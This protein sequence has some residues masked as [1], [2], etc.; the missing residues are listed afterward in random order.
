[1]AQLVAIFDVV[2]HQG[3]VVQDLDRGRS[4]ERILGAGALAVA[5]R[6]VMFGRRRF[7]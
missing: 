7:P 3:V 1:V 2:V 5:T 6:I 4:V